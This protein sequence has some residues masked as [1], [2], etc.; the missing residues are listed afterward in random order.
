MLPLKILAIGERRRIEKK[1]KAV[2]V[3]ERTENPSVSRS[4][5]VEAI[6]DVEKREEIPARHGAP[7]MTANQSA[8]SW[9]LVNSETLWT[10][11]HQI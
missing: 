3:K 7:A 11:R 4:K 2:R 9:R 10:R 8:E 1:S 6:K 5:I